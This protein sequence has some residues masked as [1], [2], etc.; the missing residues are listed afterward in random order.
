MN[1]SPDC[2]VDVMIALDLQINQ[3]KGSIVE[4]AF[5]SCI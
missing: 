2:L 4:S 5:L 3:Q 1:G